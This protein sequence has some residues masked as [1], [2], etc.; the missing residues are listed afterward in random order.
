[1]VDRQISRYI[2][3]REIDIYT[4]TDRGYQKIEFSR[5]IKFLNIKSKWSA[6]L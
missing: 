3:D 2:G 5:V 6:P 1:M 4:E